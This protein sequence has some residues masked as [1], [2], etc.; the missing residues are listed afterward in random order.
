MVSKINALPVLAFWTL[1]GLLPASPVQAGPVTI[2]YTTVALAMPG[3]YEIRYTATNVSL[4]S[5]LSWFSIDFDAALYD[6]SSLLIVSTA[7]ADWSQQILASV[8]SFGVPAQFD[9]LKTTGAPLAVG[10]SASGFAVQFTWLGSALPG[11]QAF[12]VFDPTSLSAIDSG[13]TTPAALPPTGLPE[14]S[15]LAVFALALLGMA[16]TRRPVRPATATC[17]VVSALVA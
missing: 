11:M 10:Q 4:T 12:T 2:E 5:P 17:P 1:V 3:R 16:A 8:S 6:E 9:A 7:V 15:A 13:L 14:P